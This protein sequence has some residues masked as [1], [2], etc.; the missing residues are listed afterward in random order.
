M[1]VRRA[2]AFGPAI[3]IFSLEA[4]QVLPSVTGTATDQGAE[5]SVAGT[6]M[7]AAALL[8]RAV[9]AQSTPTQPPTPAPAEEYKCNDKDCWAE[10]VLAL[11]VGGQLLFRALVG[12]RNI[13]ADVRQLMFTH[14]STVEAP[15]GVFESCCTPGVRYML[16]F[17]PMLAPG[18]TLFVPYILIP[19]GLCNRTAARLLMGTGVGIAMMGGGLM[20]M[21]MK[22]GHVQTVQVAEDQKPDSMGTMLRQVFGASLMSS[23]FVFVMTCSARGV[24]GSRDRAILVS[25]MSFG[26]ALVAV[27][28]LRLMGGFG[29]QRPCSPRGIRVGG[30][31][32]L[33]GLAAFMPSMTRF[34][35]L[36]PDTL[37][38]ASSY[39]GLGLLGASVTWCAFSP[40]CCKEAA[41]ADEELYAAEADEETYTSDSAVVANPVAVNMSDRRGL[42]SGKQENSDRLVIPPVSGGE[43][44]SEPEAG[45]S[46]ESDSAPAASSAPSRSPT[47]A[48][49]QRS[50][51]RRPSDVARVMEKNAL[52]LDPQTMAIM[53]QAGETEAG[54]GV[55]SLDDALGDAP[56]KAEPDS[57][58]RAAQA[59]ARREK[60]KANAAQQ[61]FTL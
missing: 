58:S 55:V 29:G 30:F 35:H 15:C 45:S 61:Q 50:K 54:G 52:G 1:H 10:V 12:L 7:L 31:L 44:D 46:S 53:Q 28:A 57:A 33:L 18:V 60:K 32:F 16:E 9:A 6:T 11:I 36:V 49:R 13:R 38:G 24:G 19:F 51:P 41:E 48:Q 59:I 4:F 42:Q 17:T 3:A 5:F 26:V 20:I 14:E 2:Y 23:G 47:N 25:G 8:F 56:K 40:C 34:F 37:G 39:V 21:R 43:P 27:A 22:C